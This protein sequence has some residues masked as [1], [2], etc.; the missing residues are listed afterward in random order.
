MTAYK[1]ILE[2]TLKITPDR[3]I[4]VESYLRLQYGTLDN[5]SRADFQREYA[6]GGIS[7]AI[8]ADVDQAIR[9]AQSF[10]LK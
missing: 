8:D 4:L 3:A 6:I 1:T 7:D 2:E 10:G 5:L 9:L